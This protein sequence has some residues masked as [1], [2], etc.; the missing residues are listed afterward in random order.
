MWG[1][2]GIAVWVLA[3]AWHSAAQQ[4]FARAAADW[5]FDAVQR[6]QGVAWLALSP[7]LA[8]AVAL[9]WRRRRPGVGWLI[10]ALGADLLGTASFV[11]RAEALHYPIYATVAALL[12]GPAPDVRRRWAAFVGA[13]A[14]GV[15][16][17]LLQWAWLDPARAG[18][19]PDGK[20]M[21]L[22]VLGAAT[23]VAFLLVYG[24]GRGPLSHSR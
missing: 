7:V 4:A 21:V 19:A 5:G 22:N 13:S 20:D 12:G 16:D 18:P 24:T 17:E 15:A 14:L 6:W 1:A 9:A 23:G 10:A 2:A 3:V 11:T 8:G